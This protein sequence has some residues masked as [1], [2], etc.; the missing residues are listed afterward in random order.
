MK[1]FHLLFLGN[2]N[3]PAEML[4]YLPR[5]EG[6][7]ISSFQSRTDKAISLSREPVRT[8]CTD[9]NDLR[10]TLALVRAVHAIDPFDGVMAIYEFFT[11]LAGMIR[12]ELG[13]CG[14]SAHSVRASLD[15][16]VTRDIL[17]KAGLSRVP[18]A[19]I[20]SEQD[21]VQFMRAVGGP[22]VLK[23]INGGASRCIFFIHEED[24]IPRIWDKAQ[25]DLDDQAWLTVSREGKLVGY[26]AEGF[27]EGAEYSVES[28]THDR[29][30][31]IIAVVEK[32]LK[33][34]IEAGHVVPP[35]SLS[36]DRIEAMGAYVK[37]VLRAIEVDS[38][39]CHTEVKW[40]PSGPEVVEINLR[41]AGDS[42]SRIV[43]LA[44]GTDIV[45]AYLQLAVHGRAPARTR[46]DAAAI[47][48]FMPEHCRVEGVDGIDAARRIAGI[49]TVVVDTAPGKVVG[50]IKSSRDRLGY[51]IARGA[52]H[53]DVRCALDQA[54]STVELRV[55][56][57]SSGDQVH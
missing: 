39:I 54:F 27:I 26:T 30:T 29:E 37:D 40:S 57:C 34:A 11:P 1:G 47:R 43:E 52:T 9:F 5:V 8:I 2:P 56:S 50:E 4:E 35:V 12:D 31:H 14:V 45:L 38:G 17:A 13:L 42:I 20:R 36:A 22:V 46:S 44:H 19:R 32:K 41:M 24:E 18:Y 49:D 51:V 55:S 6:L 21:L 7:R 53:D 48:F 10:E 15:K 23:P 28:I 16:L 25:A 33:G 3:A